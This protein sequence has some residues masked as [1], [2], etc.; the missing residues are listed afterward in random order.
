MSWNGTTEPPRKSDAGTWM[1]PWGF[2]VATPSDTS[3]WIKWHKLTKCATTAKQWAKVHGNLPAAVS[4][5]TY[6]W[7]TCSAYASLRT[8]WQNELATARR[9][10]SQTTHIM[11]GIY[12]SESKVLFLSVD[13]T[14]F[15]TNSC[16]FTVS[17]YMILGFPLMPLAD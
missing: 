6:E 15:A 8:V 4:V 9:G 12:S 3:E 5:S 17:T 2:G 13:T 10:F 14:L 11:W 7:I 16:L 1:M